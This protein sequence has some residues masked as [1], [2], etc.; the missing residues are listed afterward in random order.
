[1]KTRKKLHV[2]EK[3][4]NVGYEQEFIENSDLDVYR[5]FDTEEDENE[6][7]RSTSITEDL[8]KIYLREIGKMCVLSTEREIE[9]AK[10]SQSGDI[11]ARQELVR[12]NLRLVVSIAKKYLNRGMSFLDLIQEGNLG[13]MKAVDKFDPDRGY[14]FST[15]ATWWIRQGVTRALSDKSRTIR[16]PV[17]MVELISKLKKVVK[18]LSEKSGQAPTEQEMANE[19]CMDINKV[20]EILQ[21]METPISLHSHINSGEEG[22]LEDS[23]T[24]DRHISPEISVHGMLLGKN[25]NKA[26][27]CLTLKEAAVIRL[28]FGLDSGQERTL[29]EVG[30]ILGVTRERVRQL[31]NRAL[32]KLR[33]PGASDNLKDYFVA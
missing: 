22:D 31:E 25:I 3:A 10:K 18:K 20:K 30:K 24:D 29:E 16:L 7:L 6:N 28:R 14:K 21:V 23:I 27:K 12:H 2:E 1:M 32:K 4:N 17:H 11:E 15:Y 8:V 26:L 13:L 33:Q 9:L 19:L 5:D